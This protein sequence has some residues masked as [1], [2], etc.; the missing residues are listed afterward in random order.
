[1]KKKLLSNAIAL[2]LIFGM[3]S[4]ELQSGKKQTS[5][6]YVRPKGYKHG[7]KSEEK[8][9]AHKLHQKKLKIK[10]KRLKGVYEHKI[11]YHKK[12]NK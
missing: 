12:R 7:H 6:N 1:M 5:N 8:K 10:R 11:K 9:Q 2:S 3:T 4:Y